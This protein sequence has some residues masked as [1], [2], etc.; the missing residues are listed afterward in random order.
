MPA[1]SGHC[2]ATTHDTE[3]PRILVSGKVTAN[4]YAICLNSFRP[5]SGPARHVHAHEDE[6]FHVLQGRLRIW[7][8]GRTFE[9]GGGD[10]AA[11]PR[12]VPHAF[13]VISDQPARVLTTMIPGGFEGFFAA[14]AGL[15]LPDEEARLISISHQYGVEYVGPPLTD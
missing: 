11:L 8:D 2:P 5:G 7:C 6:I 12:G 9:A 10:T 13:R 1:Q 3:A 14:V 4:A 15:R